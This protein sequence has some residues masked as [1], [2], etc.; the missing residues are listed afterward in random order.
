MRFSKGDIRA[1]IMIYLLY[2][3]MK[4]NRFLKALLSILDK[5]VKYKFFVKFTL[6]S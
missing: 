1:L 6:L 2:C 4:I 5:L 3:K